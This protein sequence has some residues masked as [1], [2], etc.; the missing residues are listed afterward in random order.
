MA[1]NQ[2]IG[3]SGMKVSYIGICLTFLPEI[4]SL[5]QQFTAAL[6]EPNACSVWRI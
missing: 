1:R 6:C 4:Y 5:N 2:T 3:S